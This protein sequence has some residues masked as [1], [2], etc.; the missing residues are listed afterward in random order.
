MLLKLPS[1][2]GFGV[3]IN[4]RLNEVLTIWWCWIGL[5]QGDWRFL[6]VH[7][8]FTSENSSAFG[9]GAYLDLGGCFWGLYTATV[10][11]VKTWLRVRRLKVATDPGAPWS[12][13][14]AGEWPS[15]LN[16]PTALGMTLTGLEVRQK[17]R[18][19]SRLLCIYHQYF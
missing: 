11:M 3:R 19:K 15:R 13:S 18:S 2:E 10:R 5:L 6:F 4:E 16:L 7:S 17:H 9:L 8:K 14:R 12:G 1:F